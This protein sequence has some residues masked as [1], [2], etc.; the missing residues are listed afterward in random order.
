MN[1]VIT[2]HDH[3]VNDMICLTWVLHVGHDMS[4]LGSAPRVHG[5]AMAKPTVI[6]AIMTKINNQNAIVCTSCLFYTTAY[7]GSLSVKYF[8]K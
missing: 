6:D 2:F 4:Y 7:F 5:I 1:G 3:I 8:V